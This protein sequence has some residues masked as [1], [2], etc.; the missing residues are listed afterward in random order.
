M[1][2]SHLRQANVTP[3]PV[4]PTKI[5]PLVLR[6]ALRMTWN[7]DVEHASGAMIGSRQISSSPL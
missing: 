2:I 6:R 3:T 5:A 4:Y 1:S 7:I